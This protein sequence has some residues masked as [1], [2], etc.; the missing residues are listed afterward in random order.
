MAWS[1]VSDIHSAAMLEAPDSPRGNIEITRLCALNLILRNRFSPEYL[2]I[3]D[4]DLYFTQVS[5][6]GER[7]DIKPSQI[8]NSIQTIIEYHPLLFAETIRQLKPN[9]IILLLS[10]VH[11]LG[12]YN[13]P[14]S[15]NRGS[16]QRILGAF[17]TPKNIADYIVRLTLLPTLEK[18]LNT[19]K[20]TTNDDFVDPLNLRIIDPACGAGIFLVSTY[21]LLMKYIRLVEKRA[22]K[23]GISA[24]TISGYLHSYSPQIYGV[25]LDLGALEVADL[26]LRLLESGK[27]VRLSKSHLNYYLKR[28]NSLISPGQAQNLESNPTFFKQPRDYFPF[29]WTEEFPE[30]M[31][32]GNDGFDFVVMNPPYERLKANFAEFLRER[33][34]SGEEQIQMNEFECHKNRISEMTHYFRNSGE[35][36]YAVSYALNTYQ[37]FIERALQIARQGGV[38]GCIVPSNILCDVSAQNLRNYLFLENELRMIDCYPETS[39]LFPGVTQA[40]SILTLSKGGSTSDFEIGFNQQGVTAKKKEKRLLLNVTRIRET[41]GQSLVIPQIDERSYN[42]L[43]LIHKYPFIDSYSEISVNRGELD[44]TINK[45]L[46]SSKRTRI[47]LVRGSQISRYELV[48]GRHEPKFV[49][50][51]SLRKS[52][53]SSRR[54]KHIDMNRIACQQI[55][56]MNQRWRLKFAPIHSGSVLAN[57]CNYLTY[58]RDRNDDFENYLLGVLNS[59]LLNWRFQIT[60][61]NNHISIRELQSLPL[62]PYNSNNRYVKDLSDV[63]KKYRFNEIDSTSQIEAYVFALYNFE[64]DD[65][66]LLLKMRNCPSEEK[67]SIIRHFNDIG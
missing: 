28:G 18:L 26:S 61:S 42:L 7:K 47:P 51:R 67:N 34:L 5:F 59:E 53:A 43:D 9:D 54:V 62:V 12:S 65:L 64:I 32:D 1:I 4:N 25:D 27:S 3:D 2:G 16:D 56:N 63:V 36:K 14:K 35:Y 48:P 41:I 11:S 49:D 50:L 21:Q 46:Y 13:L 57:S 8:Y 30:V 58:P 24:S 37:L 66:E 15:L 40:V 45:D 20:Y 44:L 17:Y 60:N 52:L 33:L 38:V 22:R 23:M 31:N 6:E 19:I 55:S 29:G 39:R 10:Q